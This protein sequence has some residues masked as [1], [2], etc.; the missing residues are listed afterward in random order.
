MLNKLLVRIRPELKSVDNSATDGNPVSS[1]SLTPDKPNAQ[2]SPTTTL[3][4]FHWRRQS[5]CPQN[6]EEG[7]LRTNE[8]WLLRRLR[9]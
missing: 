5:V 1:V 2:F 3:I 4:R 9:A 8:E 6:K 7:N